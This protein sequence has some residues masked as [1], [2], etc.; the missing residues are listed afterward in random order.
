MTD[1]Y[2][3]EILE[4]L[5]GDLDPH[6]FEE[7]AVD[8]LREDFLSLVRVHGGQDAGMDGA[9]ADGDGEPYPFIVTTAQS[10]IRNLTK[11]LSSYLENGGE[12]RSAVLATSTALSPR[13]RQNLFERARELGF[14][15]VQVFD[16]LEIAARLYRNPDWTRE[17]LGI[18]GHPPALSA[19]PETRRPLRSD[20]EPVGRD[21]DLEWLRE[22][23]GD[24]LLVGQPGSGKTYLAF[25]LARDG[26]ALFLAS[27]DEAR[28]A[29]AI[30]KLRPAVIVVD[31]AHL[32]PERLDRLRHLRQ[33]IGAEFEL[34]ATTWPGEEGEVADALGELGKSQIRKLEGLTRHQILQ[35]LRS[36]GVLLPDDDPYL[37][38]LVEQAANKPGLAV[39]LG[40]LWLRGEG[41]ALVTGEAI[42]RSLIPALKRVLSTDP[43]RLL[44]CFAL[45]GDRGM[46]AQD[47]KEFLELGAEE[48][49]RRVTDAGHGGVLSERSYP[50]GE[51][52]LSVWPEALRSSLIAQ[53]FFT[54]PRTLSYHDL[55][56]A[57]PDLSQA[58]RTLVRAAL[59]GADI[60]RDQLR[61]LIRDVHAAEAWREFSRLGS[62]EAGWV[63]DNYPGEL[64]EIAPTLL[65]EAPRKV[66]P[67]LLD[68]AAGAR[69][70]LHSQPAHPLRQV[71]DW[72]QGLPPDHRFRDQVGESLRRRNLIVEV[73]RSYLEDDGKAEEVGSEIPAQKAMLFAIAP[74]IQGTSED[75][76]GTQVTIRQGVL[77]REIF[78]RL[79]ELWLE[80]QPLIQP[81]HPEV[82]REIE[83]TLQVWVYPDT[84]TLGKPVPEE[85]AQAMHGVALRILGD[86]EPL[87]SDHPGLGMAL[88]SWAKRAGGSLEPPLEEDFQA[89]FPA[90]DHINQDNWREEKPKH[91]RQAK[92]LASRWAT[93]SPEGI[94]AKF[95]FYV[96]EA[97]R[98]LSHTDWHAKS[99][100]LSKLS[101]SVE[102]PAE[103]LEALVGQEVEPDWLLGLLDRVRRETPSATDL[104]ERCLDSERYSSLAAQAALRWPGLPEDLLELAIKKA[105]PQWVEIAC[106]QDEVPP[107]TLQKLLGHS[108]PETVLAAAIG[109]WQ[110]EPEGEI[111]E[112][113]ET[114]WRE[115][116]LR[117]SGSIEEI[118]HHPAM[119]SMMRHQL[120]QILAADAELA[121]DWL[122]VRLEVAEPL[123]VVGEEGLYA[124]AIGA[125]EFDQKKRLLEE[126]RT[127]EYD[128]SDFTTK[129]VRIIVDESP[130]IYDHL[131]TIERLGDCHFEPLRDRVPDESWREMIMKALDHDLEPRKIAGAA[132]TPS[133]FGTTYW[134][135]ESEHYG[136][137]RKAFESFQDDPD[138]RVREVA[139][140]GSEF[141][142]QTVDQAR[143]RE[144]QEELVGP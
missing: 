39:T 124:T 38:M 118:D 72:V 108:R 116:F 2:L 110:A 67:L 20:V 18:P 24:K 69:G 86:L 101:Q 15:L 111:R 10:P 3:Q 134:G 42:K 28:V 58:V 79:E 48:M 8:L 29:N 144:R 52:F 81:L 84:A 102:E 31:D 73:A 112:E 120:A 143:A 100:F 65:E 54:S 37:K 114:V 13:R 97:D 53:V 127:P 99:A 95:A 75:V 12:R 6:L 103:W 68:L 96:E 26:R 41:R 23:P 115:A 98:F 25:R 123:E 57:A 135:P 104:L 90:Q 5:E 66:I 27:E 16:Q 117:A 113:I 89:L 46:Q 56:P 60:P 126:L 40:S 50:S 132:L 136:K 49:D 35:V 63:A 59:R 138:P 78:P 87:A 1:P 106:Y 141:T 9:V 128:V 122:R 91:E 34:L 33:E 7:C 137:W 47:V 129:L 43:V 125:L 133:S 61:A 44:A 14:E 83:N 30:R 142:Q 55:V 32:K 92:E 62:G 88:K 77:P 71:Q 17:L 119:G 22:T 51:R 109:I 131:L 21:Q 93:Q 140:V 19:F 45:G 74:K 36:L 80:V 94:A 76:T 130:E 121:L 105:P 82:W 139:R 107:A 11:N 64:T 70:P 4:G 85:D